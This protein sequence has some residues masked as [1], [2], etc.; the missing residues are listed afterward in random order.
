MD[1]LKAKSVPDVW[2]FWHAQDTTLALRIQQLL[3]VRTASHDV[4]R[5][6]SEGGVLGTERRTSTRPLLRKACVMLFCN[7]DVEGRLGHSLAPPTTLTG[8]PSGIE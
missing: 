3:D 7:G 2:A 5:S 4:E 1:P 6:F 8:S